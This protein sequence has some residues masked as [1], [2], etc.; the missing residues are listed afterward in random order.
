MS[1]P[2][3][4]ALDA[5]AVERGYDNRA[6]IPDH[7]AWFARWAQRSRE[8]RERCACVLDLRYG[9][10]AKE[11]LDLFVPQGP[12]RGTLLFVHGGYWRALDKADHSFVAAPFVAQGIAV[13]VQNY[14]LCPGVTI[15]AIVDETRRALSWL[16]RDGPRHGAAPSRIVVAGHSAGGHLAAMMMATPAAAFGVGGHPV[17]AAVS[18]SGV[19]DLRPL[20]LFSYNAD[21]R[22][23]AAEAARLSPAL[24][25]PATGAPL[26]VAVGGDETSEF[27]RQARLQWDA[28]PANRPAGTDGPLVI[29]GRHHL[30]VVDDYADPASLLTRR[31]LQLFG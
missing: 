17:H 8:V 7:M 19:H 21:F 12:A 9:P 30:A 6:A 31:T 14:D 5:A 27:L 1:A 22:L 2:A 4:P 13:A 11:T 24:M 25:P 28:W 3:S 18:V 20:V 26:L 10:N 29:P 16:V 15:A 23:D